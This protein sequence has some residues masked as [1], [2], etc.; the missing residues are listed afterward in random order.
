MIASLI[1]NAGADAIEISGGYVTHGVGPAHTKI[2]EIEQEGYFFNLSEQIAQHVKIPIISVGGFRTIQVIE[3]HLNGSAISAISLSRPLISE[4]NLIKRWKSGD[5][6]RARCIS[7]NRC[8]VND[9]A[10]CVFNL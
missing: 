9:E 8:F 7:C 1:E 10:K 5:Q 6:S 3:S 4:P 2:N